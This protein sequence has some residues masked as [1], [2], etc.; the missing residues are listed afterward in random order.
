MPAFPY[1]S[2]FQRVDQEFVMTH[3]AAASDE[4]ADRRTRIIHV[5]QN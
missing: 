3:F 1:E 2:C 5:V 4:G